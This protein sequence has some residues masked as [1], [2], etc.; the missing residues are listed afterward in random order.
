MSRGRLGAQFGWFDSLDVIWVVSKIS[1][2]L[3]GGDARS[4]AFV[5]PATVDFAD[6]VVEDVYGVN[7]YFVLLG[8]AIASYSGE[9][10]GAAKAF[11]GSSVGVGELRAPIGFVGRR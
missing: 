7:R 11:G 9:G 1:D 3:G 6:G 10:H 2:D 8:F 4:F 5:V